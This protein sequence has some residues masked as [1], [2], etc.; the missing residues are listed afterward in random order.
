[1]FCPQGQSAAQS[2]QH[3]TLL[4]WLLDGEGDEPRDV[5]C[6]LVPAVAGVEEPLLHAAVVGPAVPH[7]GILDG[8]EVEARGWALQVQPAPQV[9][10]RHHIPIAQD[11]LPAQPG[12]RLLLR[13]ARPPHIPLH[14]QLGRGA[15]PA[16]DQALQGH[17]L[18]LQ[19]CDVLVGLVHLQ[20]VIYGKR[21]LEMQG[22]GGPLSPHK[23]FLHGHNPEV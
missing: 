18:V 6:P 12:H 17:P 14:H 21:P 5:L 7:G 11:V 19:H 3:E 20:A 16:A 4:T 1:M 15:G 22:D 9:A 2:C 8:E 10:Q 13:V 23:H